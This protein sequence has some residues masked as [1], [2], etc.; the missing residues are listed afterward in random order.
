MKRFLQNRGEGAYPID[1]AEAKPCRS[2]L[3][4]VRRMQ[5]PL[6]RTLTY[7]WTCSQ[8]RSSGKVRSSREGINSDLG[9]RDASLK[10]LL[11]DPSP[12]IIGRPFVLNPIVCKAQARGL[13]WRRACWR[14]YSNGGSD[15]RVQVESP[16][17]PSTIA[18]PERFAEFSSMF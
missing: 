1:R 4:E 17:S 10:C 14:V 12:R 7:T 13:S 8:V 6:R 9:S 5:H 18:E 15:S 11:A 16:K 3:H 2:K